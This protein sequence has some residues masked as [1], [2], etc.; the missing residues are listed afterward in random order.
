[1]TT[2]R[3][4]VTAKPLT[5]PVPNLNKAAAVINVVTLASM[6]VL[7]AFLKPAFNA[8]KGVLPFLSS[9]L[10]LSKMMIFASTAMPMVRIMPAIPGSVSAAPKADMTPQ[11]MN[12]YTRSPKTDIRP[13][14]L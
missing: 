8:V 5:G 3:P 14:P 2:P 9:S 4:R 11:N 10:I 7:M 6:I 12:I 1:M 13:S